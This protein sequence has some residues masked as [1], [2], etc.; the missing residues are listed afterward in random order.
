[1]WI[2][3]KETYIGKLGSFPA[4]MKI[5]LPE[6]TLKQI[7]KVAKFKTCPAPWDTKKDTKAIKQAEL[8]GKAKD[9][10]AWSEIVQ[11]KADA[12]KQK[13]AESGAAALQRQGE[14]DKANK[15]VDA[16]NKAHIKNR[17][18]KSVKY[19]A[20]LVCQAQ[21]EAYRHQIAAGNL[22]ITLA[23]AGLLRL[24]V[25]DANRIAK[26]AAK[27]A[28]FIGVDIGSPQGDRSVAEGQTV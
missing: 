10:Q 5:D 9:A 16:A 2:E 22:M 20:G 25:E 3:F 4:G 6:N 18:E 12:A 21:I 24:E 28:G 26:E 27:A 23:E 19:L 1:M 8:K 14:L 13:A 11:E 7:A 15:E 17:S